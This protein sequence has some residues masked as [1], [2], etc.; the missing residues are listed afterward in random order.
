M[1]GGAQRDVAIVN[2]IGVERHVRVRRRIRRRSSPCRP[3]APA[4]PLPARPR[5]RRPLQWQYRRR[6]PSGVS[7]RV[8]R[9]PCECWPSAPRAPRPSCR[10]ASTWP[11]CLTMAIVSQPASA[12]TCRI[13]RPSGPPPMT[14]TVSPG[15]G[16]R[17]L[18]SVHG[19]GQRLSQR[20]VLQ[21]HMIG[22]MKRVLGDDARGNAD[23]LGVGAVVEEQI[24]AEI[25]L[26]ALAEVALAA[27]R[28]VERH[29]AVAGSEIRRR[30]RR[31]RRPFPPARGRRAREARS[32]ARGSR[33]ER[34]SDRF[35]R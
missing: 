17:I 34:L 7:A 1:E 4:P 31:L 20:G 2:A 10:A 6:D 21:R 12:A 33:G 30:L 19:A 8:S 18:K 9:W 14:A 22:N 29:H 3:C 28:G 15:R 35:R 23:E 11:S 5:E 26:A 25:L 16:S 32:C 27:G 13:I 24:V